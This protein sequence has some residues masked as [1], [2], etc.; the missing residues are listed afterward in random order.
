MW[1]S[2]MWMQPTLG[3]C[4]HNSHHG[5]SLWN[6][7]FCTLEGGLKE[8]EGL[9]P[10]TCV[11]SIRDW[12]NIRTLQIP[13]DA[14]QDCHQ[15]SG[16]QATVF[17]CWNTQGDQQ[18]CLGLHKLEKI[19][20]VWHSYMYKLPSNLILCTQVRSS[21]KAIHIKK[22]LKK[23]HTALRVN[24]ASFQTI[25]SKLHYLAIVHLHL[26]APTRLVQ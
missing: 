21:I 1:S 15:S 16:M 6:W 20:K 13:K 5:I 3:R 19:T 24:T 14:T 25:C 4:A 7:S 12:G 18:T 10:S 23:P 11:G 9:Q 26:W 22:K 2:H 8:M 17:G